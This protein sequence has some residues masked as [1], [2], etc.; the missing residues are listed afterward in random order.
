MPVSARGSAT[1]LPSIKTRPWLTG[2]RP[3]TSR[4]RVDL[5]QPEGP[6]RQTNSLRR[7]EIET[8][9]RAAT[10]SRSRVTKCLDTFSISITWAGSL[11]DEGGVDGLLV[12]PFRLEFLRFRNCSPCKLEPLRALL[13]P[14]I[15][16]GMVVEDET[17]RGAQAAQAVV[18][19]DLG[20]LLD[21]QFT[22]FLRI[23]ARELEGLFNC[24]QEALGEVWLF[25][26][27]LVAGDDRGSEDLEADLHEGQHEDLFTRRL[28]RLVLVVVVDRV[29]GCRVEI[30]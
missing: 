27:H 17:E 22:G 28:G 25:G 18:K 11:L 16:L 23:V 12:V 4:S 3:P 6:T 29:E 20:D 5:P 21:V 7:I 30:F 24:A 14:T 19:R 13:A 1:S 2:S 10:R 8:F 26:D 9:V 15:L